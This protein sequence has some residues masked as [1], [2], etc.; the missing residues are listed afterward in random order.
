MGD[1][2]SVLANLTGWIL[3]WPEKKMTKWLEEKNLGGGKIN[4]KLKDWVFSRQRYWGEPIPLVFCENCAVK[5]KSNLKS[6]NEYSKGE[7]LN[8]GWIIDEN[9]PVKLPKVKFYEPTDTGESPLGENGVMGQCQNARNAEERQKETNTMP[10]WAGSSWYY[11]RY[12]DPKNKKSLVDKKK[13]NTGWVPAC[14]PEALPSEGGG[15]MYV[16]GTGARTRHL[17]YARFWHKFLYDIGIV[18]RKEPFLGLKNQ[19]LIMGN[20]GRK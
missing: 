10:Q 9:L 17:V 18:G 14:P 13:K 1:I 8:P 19:G 12:I 7:L 5:I 16:G 20:D 6:K 4:Y 2:L 11:L 3:K 15:D